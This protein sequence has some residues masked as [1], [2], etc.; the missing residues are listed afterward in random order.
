[1]AGKEAEKG[2]NSEEFVK[3]FSELSNKDIPIAGGKGASLAEM[4]NNKF[5]IPPGFVVTADAYKYFI[6]RA[7][8]KEKIIE[9]FSGLD[10][11]DTEALEKNSAEMRKLIEDAKMPEELADEMNKRNTTGIKEVLENFVE[12]GILSKKFHR[13]ETFYHAKPL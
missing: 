9:L 8:L 11:E 5:P 6:E 7:G 13:G 4:Y 12:R 3:W 2:V 1:M 10:Y